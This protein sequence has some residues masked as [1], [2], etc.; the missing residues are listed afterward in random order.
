MCSFDV[1]SLFTN[2]PLRETFKVC[3]DTLYR[4]DDVVPPTI[5]EKLLEKL[6]IN[7]TTD[8]EFSFNDIMYRQI[9][10]VAMG[11]PLGPALANIFVGVL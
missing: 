1:V 6:F 8:V 9:D 11:P 5:P 7:A 10:G 3:L 4:Y 2:I